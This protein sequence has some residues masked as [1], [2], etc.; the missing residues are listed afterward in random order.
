MAGEILL[1]NRRLPRFFYS[2]IKGMTSILKR[3][4]VINGICLT[5]SADEVECKVD[6][7]TVVLK[8]CFLKNA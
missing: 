5:G 6:K 3:D 8:T 2:K 7:S 4:N 1:N